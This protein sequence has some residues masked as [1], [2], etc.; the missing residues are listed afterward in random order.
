MVS[1]PLL[2]RLCK[3][4]GGVSCLFTQVSDYTKL[5]ANAVYILIYFNHHF[6]NLFYLL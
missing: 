3:G 6:I 1:P 5:C 4:G 2:M